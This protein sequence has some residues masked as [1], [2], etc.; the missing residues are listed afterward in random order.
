MEKT[1]PFILVYK[2]YEAMTLEFIVPNLRIALATHMIYENSLQHRLYELMDLEDDHLVAGFNQVVKNQREKAW[3]DHNICHK[4][5]QP[6]SL[7]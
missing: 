4:I 2:K 5:L 1:T 6:C 3:H 7:C